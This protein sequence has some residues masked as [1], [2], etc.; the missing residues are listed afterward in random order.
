[1]TRTGGWNIRRLPGDAEIEFGVSADFWILACN[2]VKNFFRNMSTATATEPLKPAT[3][4]T[5]SLQSFLER[6]SSREE[7]FKYEWNKGVVEKKPRTMNRDQFLLLQK[8]MRLFT[9]TKAYTAM[10]ELIAEVD[11]YLPAAERTRR[12]DIAYLS[13]EQ[14]RLSRT[15]EPTVCAFVIEVVSKNDQINDLEDKILEYF[16]NGVQ[17]L[18]VIVP[19]SKKVEVYRSPKDVTI[20]FGDDRCSAAPVLPD[21]ELSA[22]ELFA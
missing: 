15:G 9:Q 10:G 17:V 8:M 7:P 13:G 1:V 22:N 2:F 4:R 11:M 16:A 21:F 14:M 18:W 6:Y 3:P 12:A 20:C 5:I 19:H